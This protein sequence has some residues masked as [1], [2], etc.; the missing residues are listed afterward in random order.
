[1]SL[2]Q[3]TPAAR[4]RPARAAPPEDPPGSPALTGGHGHPLGKG[5]PGAPLAPSRGRFSFAGAQPGPAA[6]GAQER[7]PQALRASRASSTS[8]GTPGSS[9][10]Q[11]ITRLVFTFATFGA[12]NNSPVR[13]P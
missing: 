13:N 12:F 4:R 10:A 9:L 7:R 1:M 11:R 8:K 3:E 5:G 2:L 6:A